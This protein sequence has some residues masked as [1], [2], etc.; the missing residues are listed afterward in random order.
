VVDAT[1]DGHL[2]EFDVNENLS[3]RVNPSYI[4]S[5]GQANVGLVLSLGK[6][7]TK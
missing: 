1:V 7:R 3:I 2:K 4:P 5:T 6:N